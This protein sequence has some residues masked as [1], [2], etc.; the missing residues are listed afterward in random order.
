[1]SLI[2]FF[3]QPV[4]YHHHFQIV[5][6]QSHVISLFKFHYKFDRLKRLDWFD[7]WNMI[8]LFLLSH[9]ICLVYYSIVDLSLIQSYWLLW[10]FCDPILYLA[11]LLFVWTETFTWNQSHVNALN[12]RRSG[13]FFH[14]LSLNSKKKRKKKEEEDEEVG[15]YNYKW[16][17]M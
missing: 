16:L 8:Y 17:R 13:W 6:I 15:K 5:Y 2:E 3:V 7:L 10:L 9:S 14:Y 12:G 1:M 4:Y 11:L